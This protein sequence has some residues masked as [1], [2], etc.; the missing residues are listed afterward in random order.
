MRIKKNIR[1][2]EEAITVKSMDEVLSLLDEGWEVVDEI[3]D[4]FL[5][6]RKPDSP[7]PSI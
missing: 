3:E 6:R 4:S 5:M 7:K 2:H 1:I